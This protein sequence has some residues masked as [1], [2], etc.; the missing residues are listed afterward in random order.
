VKSIP[1]LKPRTTNKTTEIR[2]NDAETHKNAQRQ[3][4]KL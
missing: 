3:R 1:R 2:I 4:M